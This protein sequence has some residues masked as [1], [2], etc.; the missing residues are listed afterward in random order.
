MKHNIKIYKTMIQL[1][2]IFIMNTLK[3]GRKEREREIRVGGNCKSGK[4]PSFSDTCHVCRGVA[5]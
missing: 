3:S 2:M 5:N 4:I 1:S